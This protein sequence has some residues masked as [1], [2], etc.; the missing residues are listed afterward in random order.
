MSIEKKLEGLRKKGALS[1][2]LYDKV[3]SELN[4]NL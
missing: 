3:I 4:S 1:N 2:V